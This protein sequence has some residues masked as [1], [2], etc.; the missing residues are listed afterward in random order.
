MRYHRSLQVVLSIPVATEATRNRSE[1]QEFEAKKAAMEAEGKRMKPEEIVRP[2]V[3]LED[4]LEKFSSEQILDDYFSDAIKSKT[5]AT[6]NLRLGILKKK[7][8]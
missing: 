5:T 6:R 4:C 8:N 7:L 1:I 2:R 3:A